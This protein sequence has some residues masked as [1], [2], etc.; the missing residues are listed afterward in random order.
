MGGASSPVTK[1]SPLRHCG[2]GGGSSKEEEAGKV[3]QCGAGQRTRPEAGHRVFT[4]R[5][6]Q[7]SVLLP[8]GSKYLGATGVGPGEAVHPSELWLGCLS[9]FRNVMS[10]RLSLVSVFEIV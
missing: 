6:W 3:G 1:G 8:L 9:S 4:G 2:G 10:H 7:W 5:P